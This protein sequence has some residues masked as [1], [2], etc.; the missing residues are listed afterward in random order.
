MPV[1]FRGMPGGCKQV[2]EMCQA[3]TG[4]CQGNV[5][6]WVQ[7]AREMQRNARG[8]KWRGSKVPGKCSSAGECQINV[9]EC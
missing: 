3:N 1:E 9:R 5:W 7:S 2:G 8:M 6:M 4:G